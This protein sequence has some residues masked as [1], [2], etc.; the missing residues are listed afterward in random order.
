ML[1]SDT[2]SSV[3]SF[4]LVIGGQLTHVILRHTVISSDFWTGYRSTNCHTA[5]HVVIYDMITI[6]T[7]NLTCYLKLPLH[8]FQP[9][10]PGFQTH[11]LAL[12]DNLCNCS[13]YRLA[14]I[15]L[16]V[17]LKGHLRYHAVLLSG[18]PSQNQMCSGR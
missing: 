18:V 17:S 10:G 12:L 11:L 3:R 5:I 13:A 4:G 16:E 15:S 7:S 8:H 6:T 1:S 14:T 9:L 2:L